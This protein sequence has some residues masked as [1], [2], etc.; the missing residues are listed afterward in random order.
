MPSE[1]WEQE[2]VT[3]TRR[4]MAEIVTRETHK[5]VQLALASTNDE[6]FADRVKE[7]LL[8]F[9]A[10]ICCEMFDSASEEIEVSDDD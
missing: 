4:M 9:S 1:K 5:M 6:K 8:D 10:S 2:E 3:V 7:V